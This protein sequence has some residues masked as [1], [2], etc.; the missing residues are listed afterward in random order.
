MLTETF[1]KLFTQSTLLE[2]LEVYKNAKEYKQTKASILSGEFLE[3]LEKGY[4]PDPLQG[5]EIHKSNGEMRQL[6]QAT[7]ASKVIQKIIANALS[8][9]VK[10]ND[11]SYAFRKGKGTTKAINRTKDFLKHYRYVAKAD[12]DDFFD[13]I[14]QKK[15]MATLNKIIVD[16][17]ILMLISLFLQNGMMKNNKWLDKS[18]GVYQ[19]DVLSPVLSNIYLHS[20]DVALENEGIA[21]VRFADDMILLANSE[22]QAKANLA[23][24]TE[25]LSVLSLKFGEDKSYLASV[26]EGFEFLGLRFKGD[27]VTMDNE[28]FMKRLSTLSQKTKKSDLVNTVDFFN[29]YLQGIKQ[30]YA[31]V[32]SQN[33]QLMLI[34]EHMESIL[35]RKIAKAKKDKTI[36]NKAKFVQILVELDDLDESSAEEKKHYAKAMVTKAYE[37]L[38]L[39]KPLE[40]AKKVM[41]KKKSAFLQEQMKSSEII[42]GKYGLYASVS[43]GKLVVKE[44]GKVVA[45]VPINW[46]TRVMVMTKGASLSTALIFECSKRKIDIDFIDKQKPYAQITYVNTIS[47]E[48]HLKQ[49]DVKNS[50]QGLRIAKSII[51]AKVK[52]QINLIKYHAR[53]REEN[54]P[55]EFA[56][57]DKLIKQM[58]KQAKQLKSA[59]DTASL[60][61]YE[62]IISVMYWRAFGIL[63]GDE[64]FKRE[65]QNA[66]DAVN[67][68]LNYGYAF[69]YGR[70]QAALLK[71]GVNIYHSF[72]HVSQ[73]NKPTLVYDLIEPFRQPTVDREV[74]SILNLGTQINSSKGRLDKKSLKVITQNVQERLATPTKFRGGKYKMTNIIDEQAQEVAHVIKGIKGK[75]K[76]FVVR[77]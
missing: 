45:K 47:N 69:L 28:R 7:T 20:F 14:D 71:C 23:K 6:A 74:I 46:V 61:G 48:L 42:L 66:P 37:S 77:Y 76:A 54:D 17:K 49:L 70:V 22:K 3:V 32:L 15:L 29:E 52:N 58:M 13:S 26:A 72:L 31:K 35:V 27:V 55:E 60:M 64:S 16:K 1:E 65:T 36:N 2:V 38:A 63:I 19:G 8:E 18:R 4:I 62:G 25:I 11:K 75:F 43:K 33:H 34:E 5:F 40:T 51:K 30:Y 12:I 73:A 10:L 41:A 39:N 9:S 68:A 59:K 57:L 67:Q 56:K 24:A 53:Y 21:F 44:Y 50:E